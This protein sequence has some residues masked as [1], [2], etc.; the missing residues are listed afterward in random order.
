LDPGSA[1]SASTA[2][3]TKRLAGWIIPA[4]RCVV[5]FQLWAPGIAVYELLCF[6]FHDL[7]AKQIIVLKEFRAYRN[8]TNWRSVTT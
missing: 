5:D 6:Q 1:I 4:F 3:R 8:T 2:T 7:T